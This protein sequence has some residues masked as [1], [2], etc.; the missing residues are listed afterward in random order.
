[1][2][3]VSAYIPFY[4][5]LTAEEQKEVDRRCYELSAERNTVIHHSGDECI[6]III[7][8]SGLVRAYTTPDNG[9]EITLYRLFPYDI[10]I[11]SASCMFDAALVPISLEAE[12]DTEYI[13]LPTDL[14]RKLERSSMAAAQYMNA[15]MKER[16]A[17]IMWL[18]DQILNKRMNVRLA[19]L[20]IEEGNI[21][22][23]DE[24][25]MTQEKLASHLGTAREVITRTLKYLQ[26]DG[27]I[28]INRGSITILDR[29]G[30][31]AMAAE[32]IK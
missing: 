1:M 29:P 20:I 12:E 32:S 6:G 31:E 23:C 13:V 14:Y 2:S 17:D 3:T 8:K 26:D 9:K 22:Q 4:D 10:C 5:K 30:L 15:V 24:L 28:K 18:L 7:V 25:V 19:A 21:C 27:L 11:F 16:F